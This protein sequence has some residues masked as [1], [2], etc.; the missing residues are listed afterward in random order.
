MAKQN[1][2]SQGQKVKEKL[3][4][5]LRN[6]YRLLVINETTFD[7][8]F[9]YRL[10]PLNLISTIG[11]TFLLISSL[12]ILVIIYSPL[13]EWIPGYPSDEIRK[14]S[15]HAASMADSLSVVVMQYRRYNDN[16]KLILSGEVPVDSFLLDSGSE[17]TYEN[18]QFTR[19]P[20][21]SILRE[22][23]E[24]EE[25]YNIVLQPGVNTK[26][27]KETILFFPPVRGQI[28]GHFKPGNDHLGV[29]ITAEKNEPILATLDGTVILS[30]WTSEA[31][32][33]IQIMHDNNLVS[34]YKHNSVLLHKVG[35]VVTAGQAIAIIG[36][37]GEITTGPHLHFEIWYEGNAVNPEEVITF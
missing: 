28:S 11:I 30:S 32:Y 15:Y 10:S 24:N 36:N 4:K 9:S 23:F 25:K 1:V 12:T 6:K 27:L 3:I 19:S 7:E 29:D 22:R 35:D 16:L 37:T 20:N 34:V 2:D 17:F 5:R 13:K 31:G 8:R 26:H 14:Q 18:I 33:I 21:D